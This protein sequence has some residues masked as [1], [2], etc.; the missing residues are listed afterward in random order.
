MPGLFPVIRVVEKL[1]ECSPRGE[2]HKHPVQG[3]YEGEFYEAEVSTLKAGG[4]ACIDK[5]EIAA[6]ATSMAQ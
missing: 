3:H 4:S 5:Y 6:Q 1:E 2:A